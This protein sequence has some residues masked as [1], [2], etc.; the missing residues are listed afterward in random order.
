MDFGRLGAI[1][2]NNMLPVEENNIM[3]LNLNKNGETEVEKKY[4]KL[5]KEQLFWLKSVE[6]IMINL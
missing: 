2:F 5:L 1:N 3:K 4:L 6:N